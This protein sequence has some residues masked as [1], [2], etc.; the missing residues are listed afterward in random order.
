[1]ATE[2]KDQ[3]KITAGLSEKLGGVF[4]SVIAGGGSYYVSRPSKQPSPADVNDIISSCANRCA[5][6]AGGA[7]LIPGP[8][9]MA[10]AIPEI[11]L[12]LRGQ[13]N[14]IYD[15]A[16]AHGRKAVITK[17]LLLAVTMSAMGSSS[18]GLIAMH[19]GKVLVKRASLRVIQK[20]VQMLAGKVTQQLLKSMIGKYLPVVGAAAMAAWARYSTKKVGE[21]ALEIVSMP[22]ELSLEMVD[23]V[24]PSIASTEQSPVSSAGAS[25]EGMMDAI[26][27]QIL[28]ALMHIDRLASPAEVSFIRDVID[29]SAM[30]SS[31]KDRFRQAL[32]KP[33]PVP[34]DLAPLMAS[35]E[36]AIGVLSAMIGLAR[37]DGTVH[38]NERLLIKQIG[39]RL[40]FSES[41]VESAFA[42]SEDVPGRSVQSQDVPWTIAQ[43]VTDPQFG[44]PVDLTVSGTITVQGLWPEAHAWVAECVGRTA[45]HGLEHAQGSV[46]FS[47][48]RPEQF[49]DW[50][51]FQVE[52]ALQIHSLKVT[53]MKDLRI[54]LS[55]AAA[56]AL[57]DASR[58]D[59]TV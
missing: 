8:F 54:N 7:G 29:T 16:V 13:I 39:A 25:A 46:M 1:M 55:P 5:L 11:I 19:G 37:R 26:Q 24:E 43:F 36:R 31:E 34:N 10:A 4:D 50:L 3:G 49:A 32:Q 15:L 48:E 12:I 23:D 57:R 28:I 44:L 22:I 20:I 59:A 9:G 40:G 38:L 18:T 47:A 33:M 56:G 6:I 53:N 14:M 51:R 58:S 27:I 42:T 17:E 2:D 21:K 41:D 35:P 45:I 30:S 52:S